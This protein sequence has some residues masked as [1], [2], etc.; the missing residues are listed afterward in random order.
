M[1]TY[2]SSLAWKTPWIEEP[3]E[4]QSMG[5][6]RVGHDRASVHAYLNKTFNKNKNKSNLKKICFKSSLFFF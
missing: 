3:C 1:V 6:Q 4:L 2:S 5:L